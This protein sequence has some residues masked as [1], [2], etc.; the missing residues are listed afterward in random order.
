MLLALITRAIVQTLFHM[1]QNVNYYKRTTDL[2]ENIINFLI[3]APPPSRENIFLQKL[4][5]MYHVSLKN[6][7]SSLKYEILLITR[8]NKNSR[9]N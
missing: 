2:D 5:V 6:F 1:R 4:F 3:L 7:A 8:K 9:V